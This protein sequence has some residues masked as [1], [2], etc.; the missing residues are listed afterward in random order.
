MLQIQREKN[1]KQLSCDQDQDQK[2]YKEL[3][4]NLNCISAVFENVSYF[5]KIYIKWQIYAAKPVD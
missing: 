3:Q 4:I 5:K 1:D 2:I